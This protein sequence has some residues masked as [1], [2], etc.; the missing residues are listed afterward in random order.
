MG[1]VHRGAW[2]LFSDRY[3]RDLRLY[4]SY[5]IGI[6]NGCGLFEKKEHGSFAS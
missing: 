2:D 4:S 3:K 1:E 5:F 6:W